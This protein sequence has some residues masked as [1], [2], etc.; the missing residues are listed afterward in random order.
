MKDSFRL[1]DISLG[2][3]YQTTSLRFTSLIVT[4]FTAPGN[5]CCKTLHIFTTIFNV[6]IKGSLRFAADLYSGDW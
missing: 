6:H 4:I 1:F 3:R 5:F 2:Q